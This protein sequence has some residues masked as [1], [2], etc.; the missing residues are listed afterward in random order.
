MASRCASR[1]EVQGLPPVPGPLGE[2]NPNGLFSGTI[3]LGAAGAQ[4]IAAS[5]DDSFSDFGPIDAGFTSDVGATDG[6]PLEPTA[7]DTGGTEVAAPS[8]DVPGVR[9]LIVAVD[10]LFADRL[11]LLYLAFTLTALGV[12]IAPRLTLPSRFPGTGT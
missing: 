4:G 11:R 10:E 2:L 6:A 5:F 1:G 12:C 8:P 3:E 9:R 7:G